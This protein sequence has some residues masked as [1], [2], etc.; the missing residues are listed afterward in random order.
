MHARGCVICCLHMRV[1]T[2]SAEQEQAEARAAAAEAAAE[3][4]ASISAQV[5]TLRVAL[6]AKDNEMAQAQKARDEAE[7][8]AAA[9]NNEA[10]IMK[11]R[12][13]ICYGRPHY[14][15]A[16]VRYCCD[17]QRIG[18]PLIRNLLLLFS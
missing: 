5:N 4:G 12:H 15:S 2:Q 17:V 13:T 6:I 3:N 11:V 1:G 18:A 10:S 7:A 9:A 16:F 8:T 14:A